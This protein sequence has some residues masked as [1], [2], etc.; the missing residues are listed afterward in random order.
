MHCSGGYMLD[1]Y[2]KIVCVAL[3]LVISTAIAHAELP[4]ISSGLSYL[5]ASQNTDGTWH[6]GASEVETTAA[7]I[8]VLD[9]L[10]LLNQ[11]AGTPYA[12]GTGWLQTQTPQ[13]V[14]YIAQRIQTLGLTD[15]AQLV[16]VRDTLSG[17]WGGDTGYETDILDTALALQALKSANYTD[18]TII[19]PALA[20][21]TTSQNTD[22][23]W[24]FYKGDGSNVYMT[25]VVSATLQ[26]FPQ[27]TTIATAVGRGTSFLLAHQNSDGG[28]GSSPSTVFETALAYAAIA[29]ISTDATVLGGAVNYLTATQSGNG[30]WNDDP[31]ATALAL[32]ALHLSENRPSPP[33]PPP[34]AGTITGIV[35][36]ATTNQR[37]AG[38]S[39]VLGSNDLIRTT[40]DSLGG[41]SLKDVPPGSQSLNFSLSGYASKTASAAVVAD[42]VTSLG[43]IPLVSSYSTGTIAGTITNPT[44]N[45]LADV[46]IT[47]TGAW[48]GTATTGTDGAFSF[49]YVTPGQV[50]ITAAKTS[51]QTVT[52]NGTVFARTTLTFSQRLGTIPPPQASTGAL[53]GRVVADTPWGP[54]PIDHLPDETGVTVTLS[55]GISVP[56]EADDGGYF[57][58]RKSVV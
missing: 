8:S 18:A 3:Y 11:T 19:N 57:K 49:T 28:F 42:I 25:A 26:Q 51:Y 50:T 55:G 15:A 39:V 45:P 32:K 34:P 56:V 6:T 54:R 43:N 41:F 48:S 16:P 10:K 23:G 20:Y 53:V 13:S 2:V 36:D 1:H 21:L 27:M 31:Y 5:T 30:S 38:V 47:V 58:D 44:G 46:T 4:Q 17:A 40:T 22:G 7:T 24:G 29:A 35:V 52:G 9:T 33:P 14:D 37:V 12:A